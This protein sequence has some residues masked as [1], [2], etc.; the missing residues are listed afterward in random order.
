MDQPI[1]PI[2]AIQKFL[3]LVKHYQKQLLKCNFP[4]LQFYET[5][6][7]I[8]IVN[9]L[10]LFCHKHGNQNIKILLVY[11]L[12]QKSMRIFPI[13]FLS[14]K[15]IHKSGKRKWKNEKAIIKV[16]SKPK[17]LRDFK[18]DSVLKIDTTSHDC[19]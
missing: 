17:E 5:Q 3:A 6:F 15:L 2:S 1:Y 14:P 9:V 4:I 7:T 19:S 12:A 11:S 10:W 8:C 18:V 13:T 16:Q